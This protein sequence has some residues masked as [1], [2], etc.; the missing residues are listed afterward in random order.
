[1]VMDVK[2]AAVSRSKFSRGGP[3][4]VS[5]HFKK[6]QPTPFQVTVKRY[7]WVR[8]AEARDKDEEPGDGRK[9]WFDL[10]IFR[11]RDT[12]LRVCWGYNKL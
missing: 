5:P 3:E 8:S 7:K 10:K 12:F 9:R 2:E 1:M 11:L 6:A 4:I